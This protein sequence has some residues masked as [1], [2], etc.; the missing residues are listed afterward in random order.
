[1]TASTD[2]SVFSTFLHLGP[3]FFYSS[4]LSSFTSPFWSPSKSHSH[5]GYLPATVDNLQQKER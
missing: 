1:M 3:G 5:H 2:Q 4:H